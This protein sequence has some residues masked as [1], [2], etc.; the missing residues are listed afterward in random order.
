MKRLFV[1]AVIIASC[2]TALLVAS[3]ARQ[4]GA[5]A[6]VVHALI[7]FSPTCSHCYKVINEDLPPLAEEYGSALSIAAVSV[8]QPAG[9]LLYRAAVERFGIP[10]ER[11]A[12]PTLIVGDDVLVGSREI[13]DRL[14]GLIDHYLEEGGVGWPDLPGLAEALPNEEPTPVESGQKAPTPGARPTPAATAV[15]Q[16]TSTPANADIAPLDPSPDLTTSHVFGGDLVQKLA[17]DP[18]GNALAIA[19]MIGIIA[20]LAWVGVGVFARPL[21]RWVTPS[22]GALWGIPILCAVGL[23]VA[24]YMAYVETAQVTATCGPV[25]DCNTVHQSEYARLFGLL[26][27]GLLGLLGYAAILFAWVIVRCWQGPLAQISR[28]ALLAMATFGV[29]FSFYLTF[30]EP[31]V[32]GATCAW[33]LAS[34]VVMTLLFG[35]AFAFDPGTPTEQRPSAHRSS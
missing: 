33:C 30:L 14:P 21:A 13:P 27:I 8:A 31:F 26:P 19:V 16:P 18:L 12:V 32:I 20:S 25:G 35:S 28:L 10:D 34:A 1:H 24:G 23:G 17:R 29:F 9:Q 4:V 15:A 5:G 3:P 2:A 6:P 22:M 7:F 11:Q